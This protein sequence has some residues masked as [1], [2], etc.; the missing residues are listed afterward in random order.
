MAP[1][2]I[3]EPFKFRPIG[4]IDE[5]R[6]PLDARVMAGFGPENYKRLAAVKAEYD[7]EN[8]FRL[9]HNIIPVAGS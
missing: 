1:Q 5:L 3:L 9:N 7:P 4:D 6:E 8:T 2:M